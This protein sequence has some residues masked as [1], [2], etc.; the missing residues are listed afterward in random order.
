M[1]TMQQ[2]ACLILNPNAGPTV[3]QHEGSLALT[4]YEAWAIFFVSS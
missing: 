4:I 2:S 1:D 3:A